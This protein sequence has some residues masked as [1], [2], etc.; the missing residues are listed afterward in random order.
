[1]PHV[2]GWNGI[3]VA[4]SVG[5]AG[6]CGT[7]L[8]LQHD[9]KDQEGSGNTNPCPMR[10]GPLDTVALDIR[11][12]QEFEESGVGHLGKVRRTYSRTAIC[13]CV[14]CVQKESG[15]SIPSV[16]VRPCETPYP[17]HCLVVRVAVEAG[18]GVGAI[19]TR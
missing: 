19:L 8:P 5:N 12:P 2:P 3:D 7:R 6:V 17:K 11:P 13:L 10:P 14:Q 1:M 18:V 16:C 15:G 4:F 9:K